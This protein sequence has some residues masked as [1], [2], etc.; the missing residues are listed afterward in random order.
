M[1]CDVDR[2]TPAYALVI[3]FYATVMPRLSSGPTWYRSVEL[4]A[5]ACQDNWLLNLLYLN[6]YLATDNM[7][8]N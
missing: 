4:P 7:V 5:A 2:L 1:V 8:N 6:N 3:M